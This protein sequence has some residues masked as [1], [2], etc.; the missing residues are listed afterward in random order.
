MRSFKHTPNK[1]VQ[2]D[3]GSFSTRTKHERERGP[4][5][6]PACPVKGDARMRTEHERAACS[7]RE[8][9]EG[10]RCVSAPQ[11]RKE[12]AAGKHTQPKTST[13]KESQSRVS[14]L[15]PRACCH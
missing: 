5:L 4:R 9:S 6:L 1:S 11:A 10:R 12:T 8:E 2:P 7:S 14:F 13:H 3:R 15:A